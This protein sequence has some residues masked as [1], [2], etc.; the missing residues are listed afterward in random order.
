MRD[1]ILAAIESG[2]VTMRPKWH[3]IVRSALLIVGTTLAMLTVL[4]VASFIFYI[5]RQSGVW[6]VPSFGFRGLVVFLVSLPWLLMLVAIL[7]IILVQIL[8][9]R[10]SFSYG[11]PL[12]YSGIGIMLLA[13]IGGFVIGQTSFHRGIFEQDDQ[14]HLP[15][16]GGFYRQYIRPAAGNITIG[17][18]TEMASNGYLI[19][20]R[21]DQIIRVIITRDTRFPLGTAFDIGDAIVVFGDLQTDT[22]TAFGIRSFTEFMPRRLEWPPAQH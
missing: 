1:D 8:V 19:E 9:S 4:Y 2:K 22:I 11:K 6:F 5:L 10:F 16:G 12:I 20:D 21:R 13:G 14:N 3:F 7:F 18:I 15:F 17:T